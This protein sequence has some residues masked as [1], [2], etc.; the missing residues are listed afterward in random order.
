MFKCPLDSAVS[1]VCGRAVKHEA[2]QSDVGTIWSSGWFPTMWSMKRKPTCGLQR[3]AQQQKNTAEVPVISFLRLAN[4][5]KEPWHPNFFN[6]YIPEI[7]DQPIEL[8]ETVLRG[9]FQSRGQ[10]M[11][12]SFNRVT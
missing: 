2:Y 7:A 12:K 3:K 9:H 8:E 5:Y 4:I 10:S 11:L 1:T 6:L